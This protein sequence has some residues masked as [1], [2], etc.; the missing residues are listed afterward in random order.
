[1]IRNTQEGHPRAEK[2]FL[3]TSEGSRCVVRLM[4]S[5]QD[6]R[7]RHSQILKYHDFPKKVKYK[8]N[9]KERRRATSDG[10]IPLIK[11]LLCERE[12]RPGSKKSILNGYA[13][14]AT[15]AN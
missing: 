2:D 1:M 3:V 4:A 15:T 11:Q 14:Q 9:S 8:R 6:T 13:K 10:A 5:F 7:T 12:G